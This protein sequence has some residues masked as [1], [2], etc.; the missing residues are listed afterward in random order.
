MRLF[1]VCISD[2]ERQIA[3]L[4]C[5][6]EAKDKSGICKTEAFCSK[7]FMMWRQILLRAYLISFDGML[8]RW[9]EIDLWLSLHRL[10]CLQITTENYNVT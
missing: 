5:E 2:R 1:I 4:R 8:G 10:G 7:W 3:P 9:E 6:Y